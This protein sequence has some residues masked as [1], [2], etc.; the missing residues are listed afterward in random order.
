ME[1]GLLVDMFN[2]PIKSTFRSYEVSSSFAFRYDELKDALILFDEC[3]T[4]PSYL[5]KYPNQIPIQG[6]EESK[7]LMT[8]ERIFEQ[9]A[10]SGIKKSTTLI[11]V[12]G[13]TI[14]DLSTLVSSL[15]MRGIDWIYFPTTLMSMLD[16]CIGGKSSINIGNTKNLIGNF[17]PPKSIFIEPSFVNTLSPIS[18]VAGLLEAVKINFAV[19][20]GEAERFMDTCVQ[21]LENQDDKSFVEMVQQTLSNKKWFIEIDE[22]DKKERK[23]LNFGHSFAHALEAATDMK[24]QHGIAVGLGM[25][26]D[27][28]ISGI[29]DSALKDFINQLLK[30]CLFSSENLVFNEEIFVEALRRDKKNSLEE[31]VLVLPTNINKLELRTLPLRTDTLMSQTK[32][33]K[34]VLE[35]Y[36]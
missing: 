1:A 20:L 22:F 15:Y 17:Y 4:L 10:K 23:L 33:M 29:K 30:W 8:A 13:G 3:L 2:I 12:G 19:S 21:W 36:R 27:F 16:S 35:V 26:C 5:S 18:K 11:S 24:I 6:N 28:E 25:L 9:M 34:Q 7:T 14:Q 31:Q 32:F